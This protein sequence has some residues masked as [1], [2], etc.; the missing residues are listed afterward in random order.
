[1]EWINRLNQAMDYLEDHLTDEID[2]GRAAQLAVCSTYH[3]QRMFA[4][5][6]GVTLSEYLRRRRMTMAASDLTEGN[7]K[8]IDVA[9]KYG[10]ES[11]TA[12][13]RAFQSIHGVAPMAAKKQGV[14]LTAYPRITFAISIKGDAAMNYTIE[15]K[16]AIRVVGI[17]GGTVNQEDNFIKIPEIWGK[18]AR[19]G[20]IP[21]LCGLMDGS[22]PKGVLGV[23][24]NNGNQFTGYRVAVATNKPCIEGT[25][26]YT[27]PAGTWAIFDCAGAIPDAVQ[28]QV[29]RIMTEWLPASGYDYGSGPD[30]EVYL[31]GDQRSP[32][33]RFQIWLPIVKK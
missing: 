25:E 33:Y 13:N 21:K 6:T 15:K 1:M 19:E 30:V 28:A 18:V 26:E 7:M 14:R 8:I 22:E 3:F 24:T 5:V 27:I 4:Y 2:M 23:C 20:W 11:P 9:A 29:K 10:Y 12:F 32:D 16:E 31:D 17:N